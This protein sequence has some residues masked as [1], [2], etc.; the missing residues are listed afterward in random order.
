[1]SD[2]SQSV[3]FSIVFLCYGGGRSI[4]PRVEELHR[5]L[6]NLDQLWEI[7]LV[8][9]YIEGTRDQTPQVVQQL[10]AKLDRI[11]F[12]AQPK[13]GMAG[14][15][16]KS[17]LALANGKYIGFIDG[18]GQMP[19]ASIF[20][21]LEKLEK[22]NLDLVKTFRV[23][24]GDGF[25]RRFVSYLYNKLFQL[26]FRSNIKDINSNPKIFLRSKYQLMNL[27]SDDWFLDAE[28]ILQANKLGLKIGEVPMNFLALP[29][30]N[31]FVNFYT[32]LEFL[33]NMFCYKFFKDDFSKLTPK[34]SKSH[35][36]RF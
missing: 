35:D 10:A 28:M 18:D 32:I 23:S 6:N 5:M 1:M 29:E 30:R 20:D 7:I 27:R 15:D 24:R 31:S 13:K 21:C 26:L 11:R 19:L 22:E 12:V 2:S 8:G 17:G 33:K 14:W 3:Y 34:L 9:N 25:Y 16:I 36:N 4:I